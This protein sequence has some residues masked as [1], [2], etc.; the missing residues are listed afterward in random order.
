LTQNI[1]HNVSFWSGA[2]VHFKGV[3]W[4]NRAKEYWIVDVVRGKLLR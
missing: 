1:S 2:A 4:I 3:S